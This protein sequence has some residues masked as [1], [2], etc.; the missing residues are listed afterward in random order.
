MTTPDELAAIGK[1]WNEAT[2]RVLMPQMSY[3]E[4]M[5]VLDQAANDIHTLQ[6]ALDAATAERDKWRAAA[7]E[8][9]PR[10]GRRLL[11]QLLRADIAAVEAERDAAQARVRELEAA[12]RTHV[13][14]NCRHY[15][16]GMEA[17]GSMCTIQ[18][19]QYQNPRRHTCKR[20]TDK[21]PPRT[22]DDV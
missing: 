1:R 4:D 11:H 18:G 5:R 19:D 8:P 14:V 22:E 20:W 21:R 17:G 13:C 12:D 6:A 7:E 16:S 15:V 9:D 10:T 2:V 3:W